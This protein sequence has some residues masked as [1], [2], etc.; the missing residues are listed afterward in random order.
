[1]KAPTL[2]RYKL[3]DVSLA[4]WPR[5]PRDL[6]PKRYYFSQETARNAA[7]RIAYHCASKGYS[8]PDFRVRRVEP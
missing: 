1:M 2:E 8:G 3:E 4:N 7:V 6:K 5:L